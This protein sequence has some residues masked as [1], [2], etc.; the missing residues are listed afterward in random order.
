MT[1]TT[2]VLPADGWPPGFLWGAATSAYQ[3]EGSPLAD[4]AGPSI[5]HRFAHTPGR[6]LDG[7]T[8]DVA[9]D[10]YRRSDEDVA[11][12]AALGLS[13]YRFSVAW[14]RIIPEGTG[15]VN[16][17]GLDFYRRL[18][19]QLLEHGIEPMLTLYH[20]DLPEALDERGG[21][22]SDASPEW[23][24]DY[25]RVLFRALGDRVRLWITLN[26]PWVITAGGYL[27]GDLAPGH[28]SLGETAIVAHHLLRAHAS[29]LA[30]G[31]AEGI[32]QIGLAVNL[33][34]QYPASPSPEDLAATGRRDAF[35]NRWFL[36][37]VFLGT[38]P[39]EL[40][41]IFGAVWPDRTQ[42]PPDALR[43][44]PDFIGVNYYSRSVV[45]EDPKDWPVKAA[46]VRQ[47]GRPHTEMDWEVYPQGLT[48]ILT[49]IQARY[50][51][52]PLYITENGAAFA[53]P[54]PVGGR[55][56]DRPRVAYL[57]T[58]LT[59]ASLAL[60]QGVDL[61]GYFA[62]SLLDNFEWSHGF[63]KRFGLVQVDFTDQRRLIKDSGRMYRALIRRCGGR[64][65]TPDQG[66]PHSEQ[67]D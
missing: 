36:D 66:K 44:P 64:T 34:P 6:V 5:W 65:Q 12:M 49:W 52:P 20:W 53:D 33:E 26:E 43:A 25:A 61:R 50:G 54:P 1:E 45:R 40:E 2:L 15:R 11:L 16:Q 46:R 37:P 17:R 67:P 58:H 32:R 62:W 47:D 3:I 63:S 18:V 22:S 42:S 48:D 13:A 35:I 10:H 57:R 51:N 38:Y 19:D 31:R 7:D 41:D 8:G 29:A 24:A 59:A 60:H 55:I 23:F 21:W 56:H 14:A 28:R 4:G 9:C 30:T 27:F 39:T